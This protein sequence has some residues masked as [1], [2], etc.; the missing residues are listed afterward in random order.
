M[1][2]FPYSRLRYVT[3]VQFTSCAEINVL[4]KFTEREKLNK[5][6]VISKSKL[7]DA[8]KQEKLMEKYLSVD[9]DAITLKR[10]KHHYIV[11]LMKKKNEESNI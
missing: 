10:K 4:E 3:L 8:I 9:D 5:N 2:A 7:G 6:F 1:H 11:I